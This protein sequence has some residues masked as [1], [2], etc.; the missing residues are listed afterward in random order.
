LFERRRRVPDR[1]GGQEECPG[2]APVQL[3]AKNVVKTMATADYNYCG[4]GTTDAAAVNESP[5]KRADRQ[6]TALLRSRRDDG[7]GGA[8][9]A[10]GDVKHLTA[11]LPAFKSCRSQKPGTVNAAQ[12]GLDLMHRMTGTTADDVRDTGV[13][14]AAY[15]LASAE[16]RCKY[17]GAVEA[18]E[19]AVH[20]EPASHLAEVAARFGAQS[21]VADG[22]D[23]GRTGHDADADDTPVVVLAYVGNT[24]PSST[25]SDD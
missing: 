22:N 7:A 13:R 25:Q 21:F 24:V 10:E 1:D 5:V 16:A 2:Q 15:D 9:S 8:T 4:D 14:Q 11:K 17:V 3:E 20:V 19:L 12:F 18:A 6:L 23:A